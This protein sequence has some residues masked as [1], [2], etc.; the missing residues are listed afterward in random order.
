MFFTTTGFEVEVV[1]T[2]IFID[3]PISGEDV[4]IFV[5]GISIFMGFASIF[6]V[7]PT[8]AG[9]VILAVVVVAGFFSFFSAYAAAVL[10]SIP[11]PATDPI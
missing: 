9:T 11:P 7:I 3:F 4:P 6:E 2:S 8:V 5:D 10:R 1:G